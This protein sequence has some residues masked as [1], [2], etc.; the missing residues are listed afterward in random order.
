MSHMYVY[1]RVQLD[2]LTIECLDASLKEGHDIKQIYKELAQT[3][4]KDHLR[5]DK[6]SHT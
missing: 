3:F 5:F 2:D 1:V 4:S 6:V